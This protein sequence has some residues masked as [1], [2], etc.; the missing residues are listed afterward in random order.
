SGPFMGAALGAALILPAPAAISIFAGLGLGLAL[1]FLAIGFVPALR[2]ALPKP[3]RWMIYLR[4]VLAI[5]M[6]LTAIAL[7]WV[8]SRQVG[9]GGLIIG[10]GAAALA[11]LGLAWAG[12]RQRAGQSIYLP[13]LVVLASTAGAMVALPSTR[14]SSNAKA[15]QGPHV[16]PF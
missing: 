3:G 14:V 7:I 6:G 11:G 9:D 8:L 13:L 5:P 10:I 4:R 2:T 12:L 1:P 15:L 16:Q